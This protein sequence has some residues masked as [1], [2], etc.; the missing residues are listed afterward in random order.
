MTC[1]IKKLISSWL[2][3]QIGWGFRWDADSYHFYYSKAYSD[4]FTISKDID[5]ENPIIFFFFFFFL[6]GGGYQLYIQICY[7]LYKQF[8]EI[9][10]F[11]SIFSDDL[12]IVGSRELL[13]YM[14]ISS[15]PFSLSR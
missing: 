14:S 12:F 2:L 1:L 5:A 9:S 3:N 6:G 13:Q 7:M 10:S 15:T 11:Q 4:Q 8:P